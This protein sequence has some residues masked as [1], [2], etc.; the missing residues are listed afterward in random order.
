[1]MIGLVLCLDA[2]ELVPRSAEL[3]IQSF[4]S[5][6]LH[7]T[8]LAGLTWLVTRWHY[9]RARPALSFAL[10][11]LALLKFFL[12]SGPAVVPFGPSA[13]LAHAIGAVGTVTKW[14]L[15]HTL[16]GPLT[17]LGLLAFCAYV[18]TVLLLCRR[19]MIG[20]W[21]LRQKVE[22][23]GL[24][25]AEIQQ[26][27]RECAQILGVPVPSVRVTSEPW[28]PMVVGCLNPI[29]VL[30]AWIPESSDARRAVLLHELGHIRR[31]DPWFHQFQLIAESI[32]FFWP[33]VHF[34]T[35]QL[36]EAREMACDALVLTHGEISA[37]D[38]GH[39]LLQIARG[40]RALQEPTILGVAIGSRKLLER[41]IDY[42]LSS[43]PRERWTLSLLTA[44]TVW[45]LLV[46]SGAQPS[47]EP[48]RI[49]LLDQMT[50][51]GE[52][53]LAQLIETASAN[54]RNPFVPRTGRSHQS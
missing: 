9:V 21:F 53:L 16:P 1:M 44:T 30:P 26:L 36:R 22:Q 24:A 11:A 18:L 47:S 33:V 31:H 25:G 43:R 8:L 49:G 38:Y 7:G 3:V 34:V 41:R 15:S 2:D 5:T 10:W 23:L 28:T 51:Q 52:A 39:S 50:C 20:Q 27:A 46:L 6:L 37:N 48:D 29:V 40:T 14:G 35:A 4:E 54:P 17:A 42:L 12:P 13:L 19:W 45:G 32:F